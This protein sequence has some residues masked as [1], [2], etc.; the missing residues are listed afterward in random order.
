[1]YNSI[2]L[3]NFTAPLYYSSCGSFVSCVSAFYKYETSSRS[4]KQQQTTTHMNNTTGELSTVYMHPTASH[5]DDACSDDGLNCTNC[6]LCPLI[7][8]CYNRRT[9]SRHGQNAPAAQSV[10]TASIYKRL[11]N[12]NTTTEHDVRW[13]R[14]QTIRNNNVYLVI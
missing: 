7:I 6:S 4:F 12:R 8:A 10:A 5:C 14:A 13:F 1:M 11:A 2:D 3:T 9:L